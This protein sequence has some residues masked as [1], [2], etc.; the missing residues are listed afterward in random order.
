MNMEKTF[1]IGENGINPLE[2]PPILD[3]SSKKALKIY[4]S[5]PFI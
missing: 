2:F 5:S 3:C 4:I 1:Y